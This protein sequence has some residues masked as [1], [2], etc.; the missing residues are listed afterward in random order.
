M[1][2]MLNT[3]DN[4]NVLVMLYY[5]WIKTVWLIDFYSKKKKIIVTYQFSQILVFI[6][7]FFEFKTQKVESQNFLDPVLA[8]TESQYKARF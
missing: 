6:Y 8:K 5:M 7:A 1:C 2:K 4:E 3:N